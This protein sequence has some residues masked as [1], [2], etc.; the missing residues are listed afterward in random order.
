MTR[1]IRNLTG[2]TFGLVFAAMLFL[3]ALPRAHSATP[4]DPQMMVIVGYEDGEARGAEVVGFADTLEACEQGV[5]IAMGEMKPKKGVRLAA[6]CTP[7][8]PAPVDPQHQS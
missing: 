2:F 6:M 5:Q 4:K 8:P 3:C 1:L 7:V